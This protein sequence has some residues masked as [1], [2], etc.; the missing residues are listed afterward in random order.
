M[1]QIT[2]N[3]DNGRLLAYVAG[4]LSF[5]VLLGVLVVLALGKS[6]IDAKRLQFMDKFER[7]QVEGLTK[8]DVLQKFGHPYSMGS[9]FGDEYFMYKQQE[10]GFYCV[11]SFRDG[12]AVAVEFSAQ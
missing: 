12:R 1:I 11:I 8:D 2:Q 4:I 10:I 3:K 6:S 7:E 9:T 5:A